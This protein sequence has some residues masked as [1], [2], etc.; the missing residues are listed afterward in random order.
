[1]K[2]AFPP[3][4]T[5]RTLATVYGHEFSAQPLTYP[6][7]VALSGRLRL[8][9]IEGEGTAVGQDIARLIEPVVQD[10]GAIPDAGPCL[11]VA[12]FADELFG[13]TEEERHRDFLITMA[14]RFLARA[15]FDD[16]VRVEDFFFGG[17]LLGRAHRLT[18]QAAYADALMDYLG[19]VD[20]QQPNGLFW[21]CH[22]SPYFWG[23][24][25][26]FA[27]LGMAEALEYVPAHPRRDE[28]VARHCSHL[29]AL[30]K[31]QDV[32]GMWRQI[33][34]DGG[35]YLEHSATTMIG[36]TIARGI[37]GGWLEP[38]RWRP[39]AQRAWEGA[40]ARIGGNGE[41]E[42]VCVGTGPLDGR[43]DY[44]TRAFTDGQDERGGAMAL[45]FATEM[46]AA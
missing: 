39:V 37:A 21:H 26:A 2:S 12:C 40:A 43:E 29:E 20:T 10:P 17:T 30:A 22:A 18:G 28:L 46:A 27:A 13:V 23:R 45:W 5:A 19:A 9:A 1:M 42:H 31:F 15:L 7:G 6:H 38:G 41:L 34:D 33:I 25:N 4:E 16:D 3:L 8:A 24:G 35:T 32:S 36:Y 14:D 11:S 44:V